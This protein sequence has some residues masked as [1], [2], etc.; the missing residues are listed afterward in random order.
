MFLKKLGAAE[1]WADSLI[2][3]EGCELAVRGDESGAYAFV[4]NYLKTP[5]A[6]DVKKPLRDLL[7]GETVQGERT[8]PAYGVMVLEL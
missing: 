4:L 3:P 8:L 5:V 6:I 1:P 2:L 7:T